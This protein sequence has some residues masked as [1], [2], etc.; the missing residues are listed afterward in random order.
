MPAEKLIVEKSAQKN[1]RKLPQA[2]HQKIIHSLTVIKNNPICGYKLQGE[3]AS[4][5]KFRVGDYR[6][7]YLFNSKQSLIIVVRI[8]HC[9]GVYK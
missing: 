3:L 7:V 1:L 5:Y 2:I 8:E 4:Y 6:I 9:Q